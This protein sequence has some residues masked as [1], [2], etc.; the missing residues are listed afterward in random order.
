MKHGE[1]YGPPDH[2]SR[3]IDVHTPS[4]C[5]IQS[6]IHAYSECAN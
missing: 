2:A 5:E 4:I 3:D 6:P 1:L